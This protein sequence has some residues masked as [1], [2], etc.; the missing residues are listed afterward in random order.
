MVFTC[1]VFFRA[2]RVFSG[3]LFPR[4]S[5]DATDFV[6]DVHGLRKAQRAMASPLQWLGTPK[7]LPPHG[8]PSGTDIPTP[9]TVRRA[10]GN[11]RRRTG[12]LQSLLTTVTKL[13]RGKM[14]K[15]RA[16]EF[17]RVCRYSTE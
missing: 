9:S 14:W 10:R 4:E 1:R 5:G 16:G 2:F 12:S 15:G 3:R 6:A 8:R 11:N 7:P 13:L 17:L